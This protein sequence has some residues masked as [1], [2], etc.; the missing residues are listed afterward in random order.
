MILITN[1]IEKSDLAY[2]NNKALC[3]LILIQ[4]TFLPEEK[5]PERTLPEQA[6]PNE[7]NPNQEKPNQAEPNQENP[8]Q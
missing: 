6:K 4:R 8:I 7:E 5:R 3:I 2:Y 1:R